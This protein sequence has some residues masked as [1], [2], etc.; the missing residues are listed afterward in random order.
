MSPGQFAKQAVAKMLPV[1]EKKLTTP[2]DPRQRLLAIV[3]Q[4][5]AKTGADRR[6]LSAAGTVL[7]E[8]GKGFLDQHYDIQIDEGHTSALVY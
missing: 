3:K 5:G 4:G 6:F 8:L 7:V 2:Q 1:L